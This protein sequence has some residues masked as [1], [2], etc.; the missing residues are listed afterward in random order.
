MM[1]DEHGVGTEDRTARTTNGRV[2]K[3]ELL[4]QLPCLFGH[5]GCRDNYVRVESKCMLCVQESRKERN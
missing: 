4:S 3:G 1:S 5:L 2:V